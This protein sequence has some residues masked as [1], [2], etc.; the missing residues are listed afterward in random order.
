M[1]LLNGALRRLPDAAPAVPRGV[2]VAAG[3]VWTSILGLRSDAIL[4]IVQQ[5]MILGKGGGQEERRRE[6]LGRDEGMHT[7]QTFDH[8]ITSK[9]FK[10]NEQ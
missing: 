10:Y 3:G 6:W 4:E 8:H 2:R 7:S 5:L 9:L 1:I